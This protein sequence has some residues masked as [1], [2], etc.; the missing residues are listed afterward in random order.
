MR[1]LIAD[2]HPL[3]RIGLSYAL[4]AQGFEVVGQAEDGVQAVEQSER[5][6]PDIVLLDVKMPRCNGIDACRAIRERVPKV[7]V[8]LLTTFEE[9]AVIQAAREAGAQGF[10]SKETD[11]A[12]LT[13]RLVKMM[14]EPGRDWLPDVTLPELS[15]REMQV[16]NLLGAG[17]SNKAI[18]KEM[19][20]SPETVKSYLASV[21]N[22]LGVRDRMGAV[23]R[24]RALGLL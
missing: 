13:K 6:Q 16:L 5:Y 11:P 14:A 22:K 19:N 23:N 18:A 21:Y 4:A 20:L 2:D 3:F 12:E 8:A 15:P 10:F 24:A 7:F 1:V 17:G 9:E